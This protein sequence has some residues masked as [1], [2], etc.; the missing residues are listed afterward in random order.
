M[1]F[2]L[3]IKSGAFSFEK[4]LRAR[5]F[6]GEKENFVALIFCC[7]DFYYR[8]REFSP[9]ADVRL[10]PG[11]ELQCTLDSNTSWALVEGVIGRACVRR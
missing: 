8:E 1:T 3:V 5:E 4:A 10:V 2:L 6:N 7:N 9:L 11:L